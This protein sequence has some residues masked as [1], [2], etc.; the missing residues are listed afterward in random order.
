MKCTNDNITITATANINGVAI[1][2]VNVLK[3]HTDIHFPLNL[4]IRWNFKLHVP[5]AIPARKDVLI[6]TE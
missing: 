6:L 5:A 2:P 1:V 3:S 4:C